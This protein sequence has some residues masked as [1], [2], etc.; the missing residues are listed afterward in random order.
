MATLH[1]FSSLLEQALPSASALIAKDD[2]VVLTQDACYAAAQF[3]HLPNLHILADC[4]TARGALLP[5][6][7][8]V[9]SDTE[10]VELTLLCQT[11]IS[12]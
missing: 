11:N 8:K 6:G 7:V 4:A 2:I 10:F 12:W 1:I 5:E 9:I 3:A